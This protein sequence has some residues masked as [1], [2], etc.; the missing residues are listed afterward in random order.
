M[1]SLLVN[2]GTTH[3]PSMIG[4]AA[5]RDAPRRGDVG[6]HREEA[7]AVLLDG[8]EVGDIHQQTSEAGAFGSVVGHRQVSGAHDHPV[9]GDSEAA[10]VEQLLLESEDPQGVGRLGCRSVGISVDGLSMRTAPSGRSAGD[11]GAGDH[12]AAPVTEELPSARVPTRPSRSRS[13]RRPGPA[14]RAVRPG[15]RGSDVRSGGR[16]G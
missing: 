15:R 5:Q 11:G 13:D 9:D 3:T 14:V 2:G 10:A 1:V 16:A 12:R 8:V 7:A 4:R 6:G